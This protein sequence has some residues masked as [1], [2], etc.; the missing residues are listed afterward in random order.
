VGTNARERE[1]QAAALL[2]DPALAADRRWLQEN[3]A[4][5]GAC[6][7]PEPPPKAIRHPWTPRGDE[8]VTKP[9]C[10]FCDAPMLAE[11]HMPDEEQTSV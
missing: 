4:L 2:H 3:L 7:P 5:A 9:Q 8:R 6:Q 11:V 1:R 10:A